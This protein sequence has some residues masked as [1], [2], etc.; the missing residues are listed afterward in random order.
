MNQQLKDLL[1][2]G[3]QL[4]SPNYAPAD[5]VFERGEG[6]WLTDSEGNRYLDF[7]AGIAV[8]SLGHA[9]P[10]LTETLQQQ[11]GRLLH[12]SNM[13]Y[14]AEQIELM[15]RLVDQ[16]FGDRVFLCN[17][18]TEANEAAFKLV[19]R[20]QSRVAGRES[21]TK[22]LSMKS[23]FHGRTLASI[24]A[25][26]QPKYHDGFAPLAPGFDYVPFNDVDALEQAFDDNIAALVVEPVQGEG[27]VRPATEEFLS[28]ARDLC[29]RHDAFLMFDEVQTGVGRVG[30]LFA[31][32]KFGVTPDVMTLAKGLGGG[33]PL[34]A[35]VATEELWKG[36]KRGSH[37]STFG[38]NPL[39]CSAGAVVLDTIEDEQLLDNV[40]ARSR[41]LRA[42]LDELA[43]EFD[44]ISDVRGAGLLVG[45]EC[46]EKASEVVRVARDQGLLLNT[47]GGDTL[48]FVP[49]LIIA[50]DEINEGLRRLRMALQQV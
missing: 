34:G 15:Q 36:W 13:F 10:R 17:S 4:N 49:P 45:A 47:A 30:E 35:T 31:Y 1:A 14:T 40:R 39:A 18:G 44:L 6:V 25:T 3:N 21:K 42:G 24:T 29:D 16:S 19:R 43:D 48:R 2:R 8:C 11:A 23:S 46:G 37:A 22:I 50:E 28:A 20:Y 12:V 9:H 27:G 38:G 26:G 33:V 32:Q 7:L 41:Q 5:I